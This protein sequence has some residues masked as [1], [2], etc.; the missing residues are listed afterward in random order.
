MSLK[1]NLKTR[2]GCNMR[3]I[4]ITVKKLALILLVSAMT[5]ASFAA[6]NVGFV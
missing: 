3:I 4:K 2:E 6:D 5:G 1:V